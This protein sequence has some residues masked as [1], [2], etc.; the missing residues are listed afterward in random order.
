MSLLIRNFDEMMGEDPKQAQ[1]DLALSMKYDKPKSLGLR[2]VHIK[3]EE[4]MSD[5]SSEL[6]ELNTLQLRH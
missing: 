4:T 6:A 2:D 3:V 1:R 5:L